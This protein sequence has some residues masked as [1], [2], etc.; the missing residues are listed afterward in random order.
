MTSPFLVMPL[1]GKIGGIISLKNTT[2]LEIDP[3]FK[4][5]IGF[6]EEKKTNL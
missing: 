4:P 3:D 5:F 6:F 1:R 2:M